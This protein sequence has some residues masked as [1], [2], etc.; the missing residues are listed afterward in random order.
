MRPL[1]FEDV[2]VRSPSGASLLG[3]VSFRVEPGTTLALCGATGA[4]KSL[5]IELAC[6][7]RRP[8]AGRVRLGDREVSAIPP[9]RR[10]IGLLTQDA[11]LYDHLGVEDNIRFG[12][13]GPDPVRVE[14]AATI[15]D[16]RELLDPGRGRAARLSGGERRRVALA[17]AIAPD[18]E[19]VV[20]DEPLAGLDPV[21]RQAVR[22]R[23]GAWLRVRRGIGLVSVH[24]FADA[25]ALADTI[26]VLERGTVLQLGASEALV[27]RPDSAAVAMRMHEPP[28]CRVAG[29]LEAGR[30]RVAGQHVPTDRPVPG[31]GPV[32]VFI[33]PYTARVSGPEDGGWRVEGVERTPGGIELL[34]VPAGPEGG[35]RESML[36]VRPEGA[37]I[38]EPGQSVR[39]DWTA[40][41]RFI[42][43]GDP[44]G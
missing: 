14:R 4:G 28:G 27:D 35:G 32:E 10:G 42:F 2:E 26:L 1:D 22:A 9:T 23:L 15:A 13:D 3:P 30:L 31:E 11:A 39:L 44:T 40:E 12:L 33:P 17:K 41:E 43:P 25:T 37:S 8:D 24:D 6:G 29:R 36:R 5:V 19:C 21:V 34:V 20:L 7:L 38:P 16:C 18:P